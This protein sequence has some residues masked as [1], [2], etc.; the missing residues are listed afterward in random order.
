MLTWL[1]IQ[2]Q[3]EEA[4]LQTIVSTDKQSSVLNLAHCG[5]DNDIKTQ[6]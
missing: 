2:N 6:W 5:M 1:A 4:V 3:V